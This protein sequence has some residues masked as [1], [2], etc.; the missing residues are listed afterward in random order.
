MIT[1]RKNI[2]EWI[3]FYARQLQQNSSGILNFF[4]QRLTLIQ[5]SFN[6]VVGHRLLEIVLD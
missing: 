2:F 1:Q 5:V 3:E 4:K 6:N